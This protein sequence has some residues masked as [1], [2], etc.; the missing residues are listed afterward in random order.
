MGQEDQIPDK[1]RRDELTN[2]TSGKR[3]LGGSVESAPNKE[4]LGGPGDHMLSMEILDG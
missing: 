2:H 4:S 3:I 1:G